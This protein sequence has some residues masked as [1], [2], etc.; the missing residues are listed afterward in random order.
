[1]LSILDSQEMWAVT[2]RR[3]YLMSRCCNT[4]VMAGRLAIWKQKDSPG[5]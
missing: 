4:R 2:D 1:M 5:L 3:P